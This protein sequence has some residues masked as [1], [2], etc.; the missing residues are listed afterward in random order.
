MTP[1]NAGALVRRAR[2]L[3]RAGKLTHSQ[4]VL[5]DC[6]VWSCRQPGS[7]RLSV[8]YTRLQQLAHQA[9]DTVCRGLRRLGELGLLDRVRRRVRVVWGGGVASRQ[10]TNVYIL[11]TATES[12]QRPVHRE[13]QKKEG[14]LEQALGRLGFAISGMA[15]GATAAAG[16]G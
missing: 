3:L 12:D 4:Y 8:S 9:R 7:D 1:S 16:A 10:A 6:L 5:L 2:K 11:R 15:A 13:L 14:A